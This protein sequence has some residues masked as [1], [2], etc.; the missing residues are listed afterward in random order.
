MH[1]R[2][3]SKDKYKYLHPDTGRKPD[4][5]CAPRNQRADSL[6]QRHGQEVEVLRCAGSREGH[7]EFVTAH[8]D[9]TGGRDSGERRTEAHGGLDSKVEPAYVN[10][11]PPKMQFPLAAILME[12]WHRW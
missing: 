7:L 4:P 5:G 12:T 10:R 11:G 3:M 8:I 2:S 1:G 9:R 6:A